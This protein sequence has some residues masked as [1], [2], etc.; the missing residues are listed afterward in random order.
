MITTFVTAYL[1]LRT[2]MTYVSYCYE[3]GLTT[4]H[5]LSIFTKITHQLNTK[6]DS[7]FILESFYFSIRNDI[8]CIWNQHERFVADR[9]R[10]SP[11]LLSPVS[12]LCMEFPLLEYGGSHELLLINRTLKVL[13]GHSLD[14]VTLYDGVSLLCI[15]I[16]QK[17]L[18]VA[19]FALESC[20]PC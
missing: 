9:V 16:L 20:S 6:N 12:H 8:V 19:V 15:S 11:W 2:T 14:Y 7:D 5:F 10:K 17:T 1:V 4:C 18:L 13:G 3:E